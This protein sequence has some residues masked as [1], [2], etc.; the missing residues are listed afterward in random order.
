MGVYKTV[1]L[2]FLN[3]YEPIVHGTF[4]T[5]TD[6]VTLFYTVFQKK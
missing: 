1:I 4:K 5:L 3:L 6:L 2:F